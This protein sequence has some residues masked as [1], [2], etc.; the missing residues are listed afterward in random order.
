LATALGAVVVLLVQTTLLPHVRPIIGV[1]PNLVLVLAVY[2]GLRHPSALGAVGVF[3]LGY[4]LDT[5]A[6]ATLGFHTL[7]L[8][9]V[10]AVASLV[11][12]TVRSDSGVPL[13]IVV[14]AA[15]CLDAATVTTLFAL[16][17]GGTAPWLEGLRYG[18]GQ[19]AGAALLA[20]VV[21]FVVRRAERAFGV[22]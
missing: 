7:G 11:S 19:A 12:S 13:M 16:G 2:V 5:F 15:G 18:L 9:V 17:I 14:F 3:F 4:F 6:G 10:F 22:S 21:L 20:P 1:T 8:L